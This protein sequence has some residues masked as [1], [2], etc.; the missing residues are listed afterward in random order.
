MRATRF[1]R[2]SQAYLIILVL[3]S[4]FSL[5]VT[6]RG[7][8]RQEVFDLR[9]YSMIE[10][11]SHT[12]SEVIETR[13]FIQSVGGR[14]AIIASTNVMFGWIDHALVP[15]LIGT[16]HVKAVYYKPVAE[17]QLA[18]QDENSLRAVRYFR[19]LFDTHANL[20][21]VLRA[22]SVPQWRYLD[23]LEHPSVSYDD[24]LQNLKNA[25][26]DPNELRRRGKLSSVGP[27]AQVM[28]NSDAMTGTATVCLFFV[29]SNGTI[30]P[31]Q[32]TWT[33]ADETN[34]YNQV[35]NGLTFWSS[36]AGWYGKS[37]TFNVVARYHT[38]PA[39]QQPYEPIIHSS[40]E[41]SRWI[42]AIM[43]N[44]GYTSGSKTSRVTSFNTSLRSNYETDW[45]Y[46]AFIGY[47]PSPAPSTFT[48]G[49]FAYAYVGGPYAQLLFRNDGWGTGNFGLVF[50][51]ETG[52]IFW[53]SDEYYQP[54]YGGCSGTGVWHNNI[55]NGNCEN[56]NPASVD[57]MMKANSYSLCA[58]TPGHIGWTSQVYLTTVTT[59]P[60][61][62]QIDVSNAK[63]SSYT[64]PQAFGWG[65][66][67]TPTVGVNSPQTSS[68]TVY[69]Y[70]SWSDGGAQ[71]HSIVITGAATYTSNFQPLTI[72]MYFVGGAIA[73]GP[74]Y[75]V[76]IFVMSN[77]AV[78][79]GSASLV[80]SYNTDGFGTSANAT[81][82]AWN[83][84]GGNYS[85]MSLA[86]VSN[87][88]KSIN[89]QL[90]SANNGAAI[91]TL[92]PGTRVCTIA[93]NISNPNHAANLNWDVVN[94]SVHAQDNTTLVPIASGGEDDTPLPIQLVSVTASVKESAVHLEWMKAS[95]KNNYG[96]EVQRRFLG[97]TSAYSS[98]E[99]R[100]KSLDT[101]WMKV[102]FVDGQG[103]TLD[104]QHYEFVD[105]PSKSGRY[106]YRLKQLD[107]D[108]KL[109]YIGNAEVDLEVPK[110][111]VLHQ[112]YPNPF[113]PTTTIS[114]SIPE[115][116]H[117][118]L[119]L[120]D[121]LGRVVQ[122]LV[123]ER[124]EAGAHEVPVDASSLASGVYFYRIQSGTF[125]QTKKLIL[126]R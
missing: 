53:A 28:G 97:S 84:S 108:G 63:S 120:Y 74:K 112:N 114:Y 27:G 88:K 89:V 81:L 98:V 90:N 14:V 46:S 30:D 54:G 41:D 93:M 55:D 111:F 36:Q 11:D 25:G 78:S 124:Q 104:L 122:I 4:G 59:S 99:S 77:G 95:E 57:C 105:K 24:Y 75:V 40:S 94:S 32:Y 109:A 79:M 13:N 71:T 121:L 119:G 19:T 10:L 39:C 80:F 1:F 100:D 42:N 106:A 117:V 113:N 125:A 66:Q 91:T 51:H 123:D 85:T 82:T 92:Y 87:N 15:T 64:A 52:H 18:V 47:N 2:T 35:L 96:F 6:A 101:A 102:G 31:N 72:T 44:L 126:L 68:S 29:E 49:Y 21:T 17:S 67:S 56:G 23:G 9:N 20:P 118:T 43:S 8:Q 70:T 37:I 103:T 107:L 110:A 38:D 33:S 69:G 73:S 22:D 60:S 61:G 76:N 58:W 3:A 7:A 86:D 50:T 34:L 83:Y 65:L 26:M 116:S 62:L 16:H 115:D 5:L 12:Y 48:D 45:A